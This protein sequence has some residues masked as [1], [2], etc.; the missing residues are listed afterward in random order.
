MAG[1]GDEESRKRSGQEAFHTLDQESS[2]QPVAILPRH[3]GAAF[4]AT[5]G[6][7][8]DGGGVSWAENEGKRYYRLIMQRIF[9]IL[10]IFISHGRNIVR[11]KKMFVSISF[12]IRHE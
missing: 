6:V 11:A 10:R 5:G 8:V 1:T 3:R 2:R 12:I 7:W 4:S 9:N